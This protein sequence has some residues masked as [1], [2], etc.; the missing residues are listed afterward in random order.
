D[1]AADLLCQLARVKT[2]REMD[3]DVLS[4]LIAEPPGHEDLRGWW[5]LAEELG[6][7][8]DELA[9][10]GLSAADVAAASADPERWRLIAE[11]EA[12]CARCLEEHGLVD[13]HAAR[14]RALETGGCEAGGPVV[15]VGV[16][17]LPRT[18]RRFLEAL[19]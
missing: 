8:A 13:C 9:V 2:L 18:I 12:A 7:L 15:M 19:T 17:D 5:A 4:R 10:E 6:D 11:V 14:R 16:V 1:A 3:G